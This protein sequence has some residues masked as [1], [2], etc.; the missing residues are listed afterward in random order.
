MSIKE[1]GNRMTNYEEEF[2]RKVI[3]LHQKFG[4]NWLFKRFRLS[5]NAYY[6]FLKNRK[7]T[8][9]MQKQVVCTPIKKIYH[10]ET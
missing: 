10:D 6:N 5:P 2:K 4:L 9:H 3:R 1:S 7:Y 8:Y